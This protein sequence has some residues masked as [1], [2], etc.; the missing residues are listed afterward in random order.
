MRAV[1]EQVDFRARKPGVIRLPMPCWIFRRCCWRQLHSLSSRHTQGRN[2]GRKL[3]VL[4]SRHLQ[5][6]EG[7]RSLHP[8]SECDILLPGGGHVA[9]IVR[10]LPHLL[11]HGNTGR[12]ES[13]AV[14]VQ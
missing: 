6:G 1:P 10:E 8:V 9:G 7:S 5:C 11:K 3:H 13:T 12:H 14:C 2:G 4:P